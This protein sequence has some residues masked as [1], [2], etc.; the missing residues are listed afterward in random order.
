[1]RRIFLFLCPDVLCCGCATVHSCGASAETCRASVKTGLETGDVREGGRCFP[2]GKVDQSLLCD[3]A[4]MFLFRPQ[5]FA[6][7]TAE[8]LNS[9]LYCSSVRFFQSSFFM[10]SRRLLMLKCGV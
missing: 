10:A 9:S 7:F 8:P 5:Y 1:M 3:R 2:A 4:S 6:L